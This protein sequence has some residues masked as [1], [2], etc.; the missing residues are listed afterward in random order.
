MICREIAKIWAQIHVYFHEYFADFR[1][2]WKICR[3]IQGISLRS[4]IYHMTNKVSGI[5]HSFFSVNIAYRKFKKKRRQKS[6]LTWS[7][8]QC[9]LQA[10]WYLCNSNEQ[11]ITTKKIPNE[12]WHSSYIR[13]Q[14]R[15]QIV[16]THMD[17]LGSLAHSNKAP[18]HALVTEKAH[19]IFA[20]QISI[21]L[22]QL[23]TA[24]KK[25]V[26]YVFAKYLYGFMCIGPK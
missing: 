21:L 25:H 23:S 4:N 9:S 15:M 24:E 26:V 12:I 7:I 17:R 14:I 3:Q 5:Y 18:A 20:L 10:Q 8:I 2:N 6:R 13:R 1:V 22:A 16:N 19:N 11:L